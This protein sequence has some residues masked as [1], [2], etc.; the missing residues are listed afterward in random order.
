M[1]IRVQK[2]TFFR[3]KQIIFS[4]SL[5][6]FPFFSY[7]C[8]AIW[9]NRASEKK[10]RLS[11]EHNSLH[12][13]HHSLQHLHSATMAQLVEQR[14]RNAWVRGSSPRSGSGEAIRESFR[15]KGLPYEIIVAP[16][17]IC[18]PSSHHSGAGEGCWSIQELL[19]LRLPIKPFPKRFVIEEKA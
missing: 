8:S 15:L 11:M 10:V 6:P 5:F 13:A 9:R 12:A 16:R 19:C 3:R 4:F 17:S 2:Y 1:L 7:L 14:I 18:A